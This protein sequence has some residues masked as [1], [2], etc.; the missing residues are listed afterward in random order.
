MCQCFTPPRRKCCLRSVARLTLLLYAIFPLG[1]SHS[2]LT[3][4]AWSPVRDSLFHAKI[5][6]KKNNFSA[7]HLNLFLSLLK[8]FCE[9]TRSHSTFTALICVVLHIPCLMGYP[10]FSSWFLHNSSYLLKNLP[11]GQGTEIHGISINK[12][13]LIPISKAPC[14]PANNCPA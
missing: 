12:L 8:L 10:S 5:V 6:R 2:F 14:L 9:P 11:W 13:R 4:P 1:I 3:K 7:H